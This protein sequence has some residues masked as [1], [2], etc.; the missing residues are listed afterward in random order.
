VTP[1]SSSAVLALAVF[2]LAQENS[3]NRIVAE[4]TANSTE[5]T[6]STGGNASDALSFIP[7]ID[8]SD[9][10]DGIAT[11]AATT[12]FGE[13]VQRHDEIASVLNSLSVAVLPGT[14]T[15]DMSTAGG[16]IT[17]T[18]SAYTAVAQASALL[19]SASGANEWLVAIR[20]NISA[21]AALTNRLLVA[22]GLPT[23][24]DNSGGVFEVTTADG[25]IYTYDITVDGLAA[26][27][28]S[29]ATVDETQFRFAMAAIKDNLSTLADAVNSLIALSAPVPTVVAASSEAPRGA[30]LEVATSAG[31]GA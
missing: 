28:S 30:K 20:N 14:I 11:A 27:T 7:T 13:V 8:V 10:T 24:E 23:I 16:S 29:A 1:S 15:A 5:L 6:D 18:M 3:I 21:L 2:K 17:G 26:L 31:G 4:V 12:Y 19:V 25:L 22:V 9:S